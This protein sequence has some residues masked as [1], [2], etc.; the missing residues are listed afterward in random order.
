MRKFLTLL[1]VLTLGVVATQA[2]T[3]TIT[4]RVTDSIGQPVPGATVRVQGTS[5][6]V[7]A[8]TGG[9]FSINAS[10]GEVLVITAL[11]FNSAHITIGDETSITVSLR[12]A[13]GE[14]LVAVT[15]VTTAFNIKKDERTTPYSA[16]V[17]KS[18]TLNLIPQNNLNDALVGKVAGVQF[19]SQSGAKLNSQSFARIRGGLL[20]SGDVGPIYVVDGTI[21]NDAFDI[22]PNIVDNLTFLKGANA[23]A[24]FG[25]RASR[26][27]IV[28]TT[29]KAAA[30]KTS[31]DVSQGVTF[32]RVYVMPKMQNQYGGGASSSFI[33]FVYEEGM[34]E[35]W[36]SL[37]GK[38]YH[39][40]T[41][42]GSWGPKFD[43]QDY[44]P[45]YAWV[46]GT[47][48]TGKTAKWVA[49]PN[50]NRD[51]WNTGLNSNTNVNFY[52]SGKGY[53]TRISYSKNA[54][55]GIL[56]NAKSD[57][58]VF[59]SSTSMDISS[60]LTA[61]INFNY[62]TQKI[63]GE[64][65][66]TYANQSSGN[67]G[68]W[69][70]RDLDMGIMK[71]L[72]GLMTP[73]GTLASWN[74]RSNPSAYDPNN[75]GF[76]W[77]GNYWYNFYGYQ[78]NIANR[79]RRDRLYGDVYLNLKL[80]SHFAI[81]GTLRKDQYNYYYENTTNSLLQQSALQ[82]GLFA[83][84]GTGQRYQSEDNYELVATYNQRFLNDDL[85]VSMIAG[86]NIFNYKRRDLDASTV[87]GLIIYDLYSLANST[88]S[89]SISE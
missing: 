73:I 7:T 78:D 60:M 70:H 62:N 87:N 26:G 82:T 88:A 19:R 64:Y 37:D 53:N 69:N 32:D 77:K 2:Q 52:S 83:S 86:G 85:N 28:I 56:P 59:S 89:P 22:D 76:F 21:V 41:D 35:E 49:Q 51:Y 12:G 24:L 58:N 13:S 42:D 16:Q 14:S 6:G 66:D 20:V 45:W 43:G 39:D 84:Y 18:A 50:N 25:S 65:D 40:F 5:R 80:G 54:I 63:Y 79:Q 71:E 38:P 48:Y 31:V 34:P 10:T 9:T 47:K 11:N 3:Q 55:K 67:F 15:V 29:K 57:R 33:K 81:R 46:P 1:V 8:N 27:A 68:Q 23:T 30:G 17:V 44:A 74:Y 75:P 4:G 72:R 61:G 36:R